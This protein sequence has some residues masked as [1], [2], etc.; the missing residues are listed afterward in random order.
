MLLASIWKQSRVKCNP[1]YCSHPKFCVSGDI[2]PEKLDI[3]RCKRLV[4]Y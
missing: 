4:I 2:I 3:T 1:I